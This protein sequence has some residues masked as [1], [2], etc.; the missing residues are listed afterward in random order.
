MYKNFVEAIQAKTN[1]PHF[2]AYVEMLRAHPAIAP[3]RYR[4]MA[5]E[6]HAI[7]SAGWEKGVKCQLS[8]DSVDDAVFEAEP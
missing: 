6:R 1:Y 5:I 4:K 2:C 8:L 3:Y 7:R